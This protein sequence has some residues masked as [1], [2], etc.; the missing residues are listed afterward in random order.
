MN[1]IYGFVIFFGFYQNIFSIIKIPKLDFAQEKNNKLEKTKFLFQD[2]IKG[3]FFEILKEHHHTKTFFLE[4]YVSAKELNDNAIGEGVLL[5]LSWT[6]SDQ[7]ISESFVNM[8]PTKDAGTH[9]LGLKDAIYS[10]IKKFIEMHSLGQ[11]GIK[12]LPD[13]IWLKTNFI[14]SSKIL[15]PQFKGQVKHELISR[16]AL[17][18]ISLS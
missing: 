4:K 18:L 16:N 10:T 1:K 7:L 5:A 17:K 14:I 2:G 3:Y 12:I 6:E 13:D 8:I 9:V 15:D 11:K